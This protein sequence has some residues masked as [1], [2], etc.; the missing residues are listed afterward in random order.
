[1]TYM[2]NCDHCGSKYS[3][4]AADNCKHCGAPVADITMSVQEVR[5]TMEYGPTPLVIERRDNWDFTTDFYAYKMINGKKWGVTTR[6]SDHMMID[7]NFDFRQYILHDFKRKM[8]QTMVD[9]ME[10]QFA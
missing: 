5:H 3:G 9:E 2:H 6:V 1:M 4:E 10:I 7:S 8:A